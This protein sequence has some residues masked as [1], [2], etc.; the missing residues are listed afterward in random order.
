[1]ADCQLA[2]GFPQ[3][4]GTTCVTTQCQACGDPFADVDEDGDADPDDFGAFQRCYTG[5]VSIVTR[6]DFCTCFDRDRDT[7]VDAVDLAAFLVCADRANIAVDPCCDGGP[8]C[9]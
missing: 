6:P 2:Q 9:P 4:P 3:P 1:M 8:G 5:E 7:D